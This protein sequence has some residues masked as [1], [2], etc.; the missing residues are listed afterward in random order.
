MQIGGKS[1]K[2]QLPSKPQ[3]VIKLADHINEHLLIKMSETGQVVLSWVG[4]P[5]AATKF[6]SKYAAKVRIRD[7]DLPQTRCFFTLPFKE[8]K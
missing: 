8:A 7:L 6:D 2:P 1:R 4:D 5:N 3:T